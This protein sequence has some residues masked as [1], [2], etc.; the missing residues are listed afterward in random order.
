MAKFAYIRVSDQNQK[1]HRQLDALKGLGIPKANIFIE[2]QSGKDT[3]RPQLQSL[4][5]TV[6][7]GDIIIVES[8]SRFARNTK[9][10]LNLVE[11]LI[12]KNVEFISLKEHID[13]TSPTGRF[14]L[15]VLGAVSQLEREY[16]L[17]RQAEGIMAAKARGVKLG[18]PTIKTPENFEKIVQL[19]INRKISFEEALEKT[20]LKQSTFYNRLKGLRENKTLKK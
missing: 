19:W 15:T 9:D 4:M 16:I 13:T 11:N 1:T 7:A 6:Q 2:K 5:D 3:K 14:M 8:I 20:G 10:L 12:K 17:Q 18:R